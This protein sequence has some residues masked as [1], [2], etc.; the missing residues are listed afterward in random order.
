MMP[1]GPKEPVALQHDTLATLLALAREHGG[2]VTVAPGVYLISDP[3]TIEQILVERPSKFHKGRTAQRMVAFFGRG[4]LLLEGEAWRKRRRLVQP[5]FS[6]ARLEAMGPMVVA[7]TEKHISS[8]S[9]ELDVHRAFVAMLMDLTV[10]NLFNQEV[11]QEMHDLLGA[12]ELI[13]AHMSRRFEDIE[14]PPAVLDARRRVDEILWKLIARRRSQGDDGS[15]LGHMIAARDDDGSM[16]SDEELRDEVMT[17]FVG[18]YET[19]ATALTFTTAFLAKHP[20]IAQRH[21]DEVRARLGDR[22]V[23][24]PDLA[25]MPYNGWVLQESMRLAPPSWMFTRELIEADTFG[26]YEFAQGSQF[27]ISPWIVHHDPRW[28]PEPERFE[29]ARF[30]PALAATRP[31]M[32][33]IPF[34]GGPRKCM[35]SNLALIQMQLILATLVRRVKLTLVADELIPVARLGLGSTQPAIV[36]VAHI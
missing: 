20:E 7:V 21:L 1:P 19:S 13:Y 29:P 17:L 3:D 5:G 31:R 30:E 8:W 35:G 6:R 26:G 22:A 9:A 18:G 33:W 12:W 32:A 14:P 28:W 4:S 16:L 11:D 23:D 2:I 27:L 24:F 25:A 34:G 36:T 10:R 15:L